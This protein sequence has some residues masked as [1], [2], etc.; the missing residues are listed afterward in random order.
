MVGNNDENVK[1]ESVIKSTEFLKTF[2]IKIID[3]SS[4]FPHQ[5]QPAAVNKILKSFLGN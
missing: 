2:T 4:H 5:E 1:M 3:N